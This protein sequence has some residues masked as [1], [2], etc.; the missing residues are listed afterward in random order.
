MSKIA[1]FFGSVLGV[2]MLLGLWIMGNYNSLISARNEVDQACGSV[3]TSY[4]LRFDLIDNLV[5]SVKGS[6][7]QEITVLGEIAASRKMYSSANTADGKTTA[8][9]SMEATLVSFQRLQEAYPDLKSD[10]HIT[11]LM[12]KLA[13]TEGD[14]K[15]ARDGYN[16]IVTNYNTN[17]ESFPKSVFAS[18]WGFTKRSL[19][20]SDA[21]AARAVKVNF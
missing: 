2:A 5:S 16:H 19:F 4:Q 8:I 15:V 11:A 1:I 9:N 13:E 10:A 20:K 17:V 7:K 18:S 21:S 3:E 6:Q 12:N 14:I